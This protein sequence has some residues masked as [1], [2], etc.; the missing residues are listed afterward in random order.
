MK[1]FYFNNGIKIDPKRIK[2]I[3]GEIYLDGILYFW[4]DD[5]SSREHPMC[6]CKMIIKPEDVYFDYCTKYFVWE[7]TEE[8]KENN[9][10]RN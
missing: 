5:G 4:E 8:C 7:Y 3:N 9:M 2:I 10:W 6:R 1:D